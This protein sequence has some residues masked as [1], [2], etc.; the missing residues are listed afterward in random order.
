MNLNLLKFR[1]VELLAQHKKVTAVAELLELKQPTV[2]FHMKNLEKEFGVQLFESRAGKTYLTEAGEAL[3]HYA[4]KIN[5]LA[6]DAERVVK[7]FDQLERGSIR[8][9][10]SYVPATYILP[11]ILSS[12]AKRYPQIMISLVVKASPVIKDMLLNHEIDIGIMSTQPFQL[13]PL[14]SETICKDEL[15]VIFSP[16]H[17]LAQHPELNPGLLS[18]VPFILHGL[19]SSTRQL[20]DKWALTNGISLNAYLEL[21][22]LE[23]IKQSVMLGDSAAFISKLAVNK[24]SGRGELEF[25]PIP[26]NL[27]K[28]NVYLVYNQ[29]RRQS[30]LIVQ[31]IQHL[32]Q[33]SKKYPEL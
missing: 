32:R 20:T 6:Q 24:E 10:A 17:S 28:R 5:V 30:A 1:I 7:E 18:E 25:R 8:I 14:V 19:E 21:D 26:H 23:A 33:S 29:E 27:F 11:A 22:S 4:H 15:V 13:P 12:F 2:T 3:R 16:Q 31:F 9:G